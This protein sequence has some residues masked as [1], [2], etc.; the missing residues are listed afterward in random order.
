MADG[1]TSYPSLAIM[2]MISCADDLMDTVGKMGPCDNEKGN[3][4][5]IICIVLCLCIYQIQLG[6][7]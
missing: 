2:K 5:N 6:T 1:V 3:N 7:F 4:R